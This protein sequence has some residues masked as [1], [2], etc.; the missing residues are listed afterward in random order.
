[1]TVRKSPSLPCAKHGAY[2]TA[3]PVFFSVPHPSG[4]GEAAGMALV[5]SFGTMTASFS[6]GMLAEFA[7]GGASSLTISALHSTSYVTVTR[8]VWA[9]PPWTRSREPTPQILQPFHRRP[10]FDSCYFLQRGPG[11]SRA[12]RFRERQI[13]LMDDKSF[14]PAAA[15]AFRVRLSSRG[16]RRNPPESPTHHPGDRRLSL[17]AG[18]C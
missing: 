7:G 1:M 16:A 4:A 18:L 10:I 15:A 17:R 13:L 12:F 11:I 9:P 14:R 2:P 5:A 6:A 3:I 8:P